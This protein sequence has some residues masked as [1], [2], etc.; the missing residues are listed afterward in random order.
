M[1]HL[2]LEIFDLTAGSNGEYGSKYA[3]LPKNTSITITDTSELFAQ[4]DVWSHSFTLNVRANVHIFGTAGDMHGARLHEQINRRRVRLWAE[5]L[6]LYLGY[7]TLGDEAE[8]D[9]EGNVDVGFESGQKTFDEMIEG[10]K[11]NQV[12]MMG[13]VEIGMALWRKRWTRFSVKLEASTTIGIGEV[14][15]TISGPVTRD[16]SD[17]FTF[18]YDGEVDGNSVQ[19]YPRMV[20]PKGSFT[21]RETNQAWSEN[22]LNT[23]N[24]YTE[25]ANGVPT[26]PYCNIGLCY[27]RYD[28]KKTDK[29]GNVTPAYDEEPEAQRG[30]E[31]MPPNRVNS[32]PCF[33]VIYWIRCLM[34]HLGIYVEENQMM[35]VEDLRRL[36]FVNTKC[37]YVEPKK[38]RTADYNERFGRYKC[39]S[40]IR[41]L[42]P[43]YVN[44]EKNVDKEESGLK[45]L[46]IKLTFGGVT[47]DA[48]GGL[49][50]KV[51][52]ISKWSADDESKYL[53][54]NNYFHR[55]YATSECF[56]DADIS[57]VIKAIESGFGIRFLFTDSYRRVRIVLL[58]NVFRSTDVQDIACNVTS[59]QKTENPIRGFRMTYG[60]N[61]DNTEFFYK[62]FDDMLPKKKPYFTDDS[63]KHDYSFWDLN[64]DYSKIINKVSAFDKTCYVTPNTG[65][66]YGIK[67]DK[68]AKRYDQLHPSLFEFAG[69]MDAE[70]GDCT[71]EDN[72]IDTINVGFVPA[73]VNDLNMEDERKGVYRQR[74][75][76]FV[77]ETMRPRRYNYKDPD[78]RD[79][80]S[81]PSV[82]YDVDEIYRE[83]SPAQSMTN[84]G[85]VMPGVFAIKSDMYAYD[86]GLKATLVLQN[87]MI[88]ISVDASFDADGH[89]YEGYH[90][91][92]Q[93]NFEPNDTGICPI[94]THDWGL[95]LGIMRGSG[96]D[97]YVEASYDPDD[98]EGNNTW[99]I[100]PGSNAT[101]H[102]DTCDNYGNEWDYNGYTR[103]I[104]TKQ[105]AIVALSE[106]FPNSNAPFYISGYNGGYINRASI[107][108]ILDNEGKSHAI[109]IAIQRG[110]YMIDF[111]QDYI[112]SW[113]GHSAEEI[114]TMDKA[115]Y[116]I[117]IEMDSSQERAS[118]L[119]ELCK[120]AYDPN[121]TPS[122]DMTIDDN[123]VGSRY[124][125]FSLKLR[126]EKLNP[127]FNP[128]LPENETTNRRYL[129][130][131][132]ENLQ[133]RGL[134]DQFYKEYSYWIRNARIANMT[135]EMTLAQL[136]AIDKTKKVRINDITGFIRK[137]QYSVNNE[138]GLGMVAMEIMYI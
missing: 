99:D 1:E 7:L 109:L 106:M 101:A 59:Q 37:D 63:D 13:D 129:K 94:E 45:G 62:G 113:I 25:D 42:I 127:F 81:D 18:Q 52:E 61:K 125:R 2:A 117:I 55:A 130:I 12:P 93:D 30:Y 79:Y 21:D 102:P 64:A 33:Y 103:R 20:F 28:Y 27:Q 134:C 3:F 17:R 114:M 49:S 90:L 71:G 121:Y 85:I 131:D 89:I 57:E 72:T 58:K 65:D 10:A 9:E 23:D 50:I 60:D 6:P 24:S 111:G 5:G 119:L 44:S 54:N 107:T 83:G 29:D 120:R 31:Y 115:G 36:F 46:N 34:K 78:D 74:F 133:Q 108:H 118:T 43:E 75:A 56:P 53:D 14:E 35:D 104:I 126:A 8:V 88:P 16:G 123:G 112:P 100:V 124:G 110:S 80:F 97:A 32:A 128:K 66:A 67:V 96:D 26:H 19:E 77:D 39:S 84:D 73:I 82:V 40:Y 136:L 132:D 22:C 69:Y 92:L 47:V 4:G 51:S 68:D 98:G 11:A 87:A 91:Y 86:T 138:T 70:D 95:T 116:K 76:L 137:M 105:D 41:K 38:L 135:V 48:S 122:A 15:R